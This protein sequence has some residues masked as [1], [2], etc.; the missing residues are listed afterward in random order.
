[1]HLRD[2]SG[3]S[4]ITRGVVVTDESASSPITAVFGVAI[5][6]LFLLLAVQVLLHLYTTSVVGTAAFEAARLHASGDALDRGVAQERAAALMGDYGAR[7]DFD[8]AGTDDE[9]VVLRVTG[10]SPAVLIRA[11]GQ[12]TGLDTIDRQVRVRVERFRPVDAEAA[13]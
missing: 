12:L 11:V 8:W 4:P 1:M 2:E 6:L 10:P 9:Q 13:R 3:S 5:F 7:V